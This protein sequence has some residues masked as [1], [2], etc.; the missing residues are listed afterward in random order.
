MTTSAEEQEEVGELRGGGGG[1]G[2]DN[3]KNA[4]PHS[5]T[6]SAVAAEAAA[7]A[8]EEEEDAAAAAVEA[9]FGDVCAICQEDVSLRGKID[10]CAHLFCLPCVKRWAKIE[11]RCPLCKARFT[12]IQPEDMQEDTMNGGDGGGGVGDGGDEVHGA[13]TRAT[14]SGGERQKKPT[15]KKLKPIYLPHRD[16]VRLHSLPGVR[17]FT[18]SIPAVINWWCLDCKITC[19]RS[20]NPTAG[21]TK[22]PT[23]ASC[24][25]ATWR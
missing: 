10:S 8:E 17:L 21:C 3:D 6:S 13:S 22:T 20:A 16:Q 23:E 7:A 1:D 19:V 18:W 24:E 25:A 14:R 4:G 9:I 2:T 11:T 5:P 12:F 15:T